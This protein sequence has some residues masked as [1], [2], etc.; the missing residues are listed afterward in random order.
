MNDE[1]WLEVRDVTTLQ[2]GEVLRCKQLTLSGGSMRG[3]LT[4]EMNDPRGGR[5]VLAR[6][7]MFIV[8]WALIFKEEY[9]N[10]YWCAYFFVAEA[11]RQQGIGRALADEVTNLTS[12]AVRVYRNNTNAPFFNKVR[13]ERLIDSITNMPIT[14]RVTSG[15]LIEGTA[16]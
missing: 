16:R 13:H 1:V 3:Q 2:R 12:E 8:G 11:D 15:H 6:Q 10:G 9:P 5:V 4:L 7:G 14:Q